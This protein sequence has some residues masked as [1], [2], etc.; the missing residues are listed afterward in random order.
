MIRETG[1]IWTEKRWRL[2]SSPE[3]EVS[4][5]KTEELMSE[6]KERKEEPRSKKLNERRWWDPRWSSERGLWKTDRD[7]RR[8][9]RSDRRTGTGGKDL[10]EV[11]IEK[12]LAEERQ[13]PGVT[14]RESQVEQW[15]Y[16]DQR[17]RRSRWRR[18]QAGCR[19][20]SGVIC[21]KT[22]TAK[23][24]GKFWETQS[25]QVCFLLRQRRKKERRR[26]CVKVSAVSHYRC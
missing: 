22:S 5:E 26:K 2:G 23:L 21:D 11:E 4:Q 9:F 25:E 13:R 10:R 1:R 15:D 6:E 3:V 7:K 19:M 12:K 17:S 18:V 14:E 16:K 24:K 20:V 8:L